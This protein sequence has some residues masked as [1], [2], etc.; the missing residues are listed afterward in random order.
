[1][2]SDGLTVFRS[3]RVSYTAGFLIIFSFF[4]LLRSF[5]LDDWD[6]VL[7]A[8][9]LDG[10]DL[11]AHHPHPP[12]YPVYVFLARILYWLLGDKQLALVVLSNLSAT[13]T[14]VL[15]V[16]LGRLI[17]N[18]VAGVI[19]AIVLFSAPAFIQA[20]QVAMTDIVMAPFLVGSAVCFLR[21][22]ARHG[23]SRTV[24]IV[25][26]AACLGFGVGVRPQALLLYSTIGLL[27]GLRFQSWTDRAALIASGLVATLAWLVPMSV[28]SGGLVEY[29]ELCRRQFSA[30]P[31]ARNKFAIV[32]FARFG[33]LLA[34]DWQRPLLL[35]LVLA[36]VSV[37]LV[38]IRRGRPGLPALS[39]N[40]TESGVPLLLVLLVMTG[41]G[42]LTTL[43]FHPLTFDRVLLPA[44]V[45]GAFF[46][47]VAVASAWKALPS[48]PGFRPVFALTLA[49]ATYMGIEGSLSRAIDLHQSTPAAVQAAQVI[50]QTASADA[51]L[52]QAE[53]AFRHWQYYLPDYP[54]LD[55]YYSQRWKPWHPLPR[56]RFVFSQ[57]AFQ[58][59]PPFQSWRFER[60]PSIYAKLSRLHM[61][62]YKLEH[63]NVFLTSGT[64]RSESWGFWT[65]DHVDGFIRQSADGESRLFVRIRSGFRRPRTLLIRVD[66]KEAWRGTI[67]P[68]FTRLQIP[69][70]LSRQ[71]TP[72]SIESPEGCERP[73]ELGGAT[74]AR[75]LSFA[76]EHLDVGLVK[77]GLGQEL[78]FT[79]ESGHVG[80]LQQGWSDPEAVGTWSDGPQASIDLDLREGPIQD[81]VLRFHGGFFVDEIH[82]P[83]TRFHVSANGRRVFSG[84]ETV[85]GLRDYRVAIPVEAQRSD[86]RLRIMFELENP[87]APADLGLSVDTRRLG[88]VLN[89]LSL[90]TIAG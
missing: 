76:I 90:G 68:H 50:E 5:W 42:V 26:G 80:Y 79:E 19:A 77:L 29:V 78:L 84:I 83:S 75:C 87:E 53:G 2:T 69:L 21:A 88:V 11:V 62:Q 86:G 67:P 34:Q 38:L 1:M 12:G 25:A 52:L 3:P 39:T 33:E 47:G 28:I 24:L 57:R 65:T 49:I 82:H 51:T 4:F 37:L 36:L 31:D 81:L 72:L 13:G 89:R 48:V 85:R 63:M 8:H 46:T 61:H 30:H 55:E 18:P 45:P 22:E 43:L 15:L 64:Y 58:G 40:R 41:V 74:D 10:M 20:G 73:S 35:F 59:S 66:G 44:L 6:S 16:E 56:Q 7:F 60:S 70:E 17:K 54:T 9:A 14:L 71:W 27:F 23:R 32:D